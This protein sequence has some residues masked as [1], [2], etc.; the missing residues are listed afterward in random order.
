[1]YT[2]LF[3]LA[4]IVLL[5]HP[6]GKAINY[7]LTITTFILYSL[8][9]A[10]IALNWDNKWKGLVIISCSIVTITLKLIS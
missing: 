1:M 9:T 8:C 10:H 2:I 3:V 4:V 6:R 7:P 5:G